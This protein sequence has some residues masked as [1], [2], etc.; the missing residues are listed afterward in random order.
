MNDYENAIHADIIDRPY[1]SRFL[2]HLRPN[3]KILD[4]GCGSGGLTVI[5]EQE[6]FAPIG[7]DIS[8]DF[9][10]LAQCAYPETQFL[11]ADSEEL[12]RMN[13]KF[14]AIV[15]A[16]SLIHLE[17]IM[18]PHVLSDFKK[19]LAPDGYL[20]LSLQTDDSDEAQQILRGACGKFPI[21][22]RKEFRLFL[23]LFTPTEIRNELYSQGFEVVDIQ[24]REPVENEFPFRKM[25]VIA[26]ST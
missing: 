19:I 6:G 20:F 26:K 4:Y 16:Y 23:K 18:V 22:Y 3:S 15:A 13:L 12:V 5:L 17:M 25:F 10:C 8:N 11:K 21:P 2:Q 14:D 24:Y 9:V 1:I 7:S